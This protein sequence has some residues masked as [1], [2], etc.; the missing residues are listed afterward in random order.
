VKIICAWCEKEIEDIAG[1]DQTSKYEVSHGICRPCK[2]RFLSNEEHTLERFLNK[3]E[4]PVLVV[5][6]AGEVMLANKAALDLL[7]KRMEQVKGYR[8]GDVMECGYA[9]LPGGCGNTQH[10][11]A[12]TIRNNVMETFETAES[13]RRVPAYVNRQG[14]RGRQIVDYLISTEKVSEYVLLRIDD[15]SIR[16]MES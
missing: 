6:K 11:V 3:L 7:G 2:E 1:Q 13:K 12:C 15:V 10:C 8:G 4:A 9:A 16:G 5:N 14:E